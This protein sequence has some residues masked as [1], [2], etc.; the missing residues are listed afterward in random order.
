M[1]HA[2]Q[3]AHKLLRPGGLLINVHDLPVPHLIELAAT[4]AVHKAGWISDKD[5]Y[6]ATRA[7]LNTIVQVAADGLFVLE[8]ERNFIYTIYAD[9]LDELRAFLAEWWESALLP[10]RTVQRLD[11]FAAETSDPTRIAIRLQARMTKLRAV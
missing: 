6:D 4:D 1:V 10:E 11:A 5:D 7:S 8:D 3:L 2:L 9:N